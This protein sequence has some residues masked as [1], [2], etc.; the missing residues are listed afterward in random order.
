MPK[1]KLYMKSH[2]L[3]VI[4][5][6]LISNCDSMDCE[7]LKTGTFRLHGED[8]TTHIIKRTETHQSE[9]IEESGLVSEFDIEWSNECEYKLFKRRVTAGTDRYPDMIIDTLF[10]E[11]LDINGKFHTTKT[12]SKEYKFT[13][14][15]K[16]EKIE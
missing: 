10:C 12:S 3:L 1:N 9:T 7:N 14:T 13:A 6:F 8:G 5:V 4:L 15:A 16:L 11:I 2:F